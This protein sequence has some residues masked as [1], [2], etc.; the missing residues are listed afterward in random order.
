VMGGGSEGKTFSHRRVKG[1]TAPNSIVKNSGGGEA[2]SA[3]ILP[4]GG[5]GGEEKPA[6]ST[7]RMEERN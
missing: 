6:T 3:L 1:K 5:E 2:C 7:L 4:E